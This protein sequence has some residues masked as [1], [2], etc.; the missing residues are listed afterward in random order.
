M[1]LDRSVIPCAVHRE[2]AHGG[3]PSGP[4]RWIGQRAGDRGG[5]GRGG[6][7]TRG[8]AL[9][10]GRVPSPAPTQPMVGASPRGSAR[11]QWPAAEGAHRWI[12]AEAPGCL[13]CPNPRPFGESVRTAVVRRRRDPTARESP[14]PCP[15]SANAGRESPWFGAGALVRFCSLPPGGSVRDQWSAAEGEPR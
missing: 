5:D 4:D 13:P 10:P 2:S 15:D 1:S 14:L 7:H 12:G 8:E 9:Q 3:R 11:D 6:G